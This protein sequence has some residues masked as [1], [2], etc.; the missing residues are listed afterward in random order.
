MKKIIIFVGLMGLLAVVPANGAWQTV[1]SD[2]FNITSPPSLDQN[3]ELAQRQSGS[4]AP[5]LWADFGTG[6][7][8]NG[9]I[10][11]A[12]VAINTANQLQITVKGEEN[13]DISYVRVIAPAQ[14]GLP[15]VGRYRLKWDQGTSTDWSLVRFNVTEPNWIGSSLPDCG[16]MVHGNSQPNRITFWK[17]GG[18]AGDGSQFSFPSGENG[19][20]HIEVDANNGKIDVYVDGDTSPTWTADF[21]T[22]GTGKTGVG[23]VSLTAYASG[24]TYGVPEVKGYMDNFVYEVYIPE[25][26]GDVGTQYPVGDLTGLNGIKDC[27]VNFLDFAFLA[28]QWLDCTDPAISTCTHWW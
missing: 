2:N 4:K 6:N 8:Q 12:N 14:I 7:T 20:H 15:Q 17:N 11:D 10:Y 25:Y 3:L 24:P 18:W 28:K 21:S 1:L 5:R 13:P 27:Q 22:V 16:I 9:G 19:L 23:V 26:C